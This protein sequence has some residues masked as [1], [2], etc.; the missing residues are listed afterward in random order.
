MMCIIGALSMMSVHYEALGKCFQGEK[1]TLFGPH[2]PLIGG[3]FG[4]TA[5][6]KC[7]KVVR[8]FSS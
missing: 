8:V 2:F 5:R 1:G 3:A 6:D 7:G 4:K